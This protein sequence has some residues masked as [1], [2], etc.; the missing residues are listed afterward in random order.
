ML[1]YQ[2]TE[3]Y[4]F[5]DHSA[6][7]HGTVMHS[8][9]EYTLQKAMEFHGFSVRMWSANGRF[10][11]SVLALDVPSICVLASWM[12]MMCRLRVCVCVCQVETVLI[13]M[14][15]GT[16]WYLWYS[17]TKHLFNGRF[18]IICMKTVHPKCPNASAPFRSRWGDLW[19]INSAGAEACRQAMHVTAWASML[20]GCHGLSGLLSSGQP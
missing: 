15:H 9:L 20:S 17:W 8:T 2:F 14:Q 16:E 4:M 19:L 11:V 10:W 3:G 6:D 13:L 12:V 7:D 18:F 5:H 1:V